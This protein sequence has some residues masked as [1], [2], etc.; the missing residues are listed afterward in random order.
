M[1]T[2]KLIGQYNLWS[3]FDKDSQMYLKMPRL[4]KKVKCEQQL[5]RSAC[6]SVHSDKH[7]TVHYRFQIRSV[8]AKLIGL[9]IYVLIGRYVN[10]LR[11]LNYFGT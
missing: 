1:I 2:A 6:T 4:A 10:A 5:S 3:S 11:V 8:L 9:N 7:F